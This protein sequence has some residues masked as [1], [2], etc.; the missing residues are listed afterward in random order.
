MIVENSSGNKNDLYD[1]MLDVVLLE[2]RYAT[3]FSSLGMEDLIR[4]RM[5]L[6][7]IRDVKNQLQKG[8][9]ERVI[10]I[11]ADIFENK[12]NKRL[13]VNSSMIKNLQV[14]TPLDGVKKTQTWSERNKRRTSILDVGSTAVSRAVM[15]HE[16]RNAAKFFEIKYRDPIVPDSIFYSE[17]FQKIKKENILLSMNQA[18]HKFFANKEDKSNRDIVCSWLSSL[19]EMIDISLSL[20]KVLMDFFKLEKYTY[21]YGSLRSPSVPQR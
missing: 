19:D 21:E 14:D 8:V 16:K 5:M 6:A 9:K 13:S 7:K 12:R 3:L 20:M 15:S 2:K 17:P 4:K 11:P 10:K 1:P 18:V